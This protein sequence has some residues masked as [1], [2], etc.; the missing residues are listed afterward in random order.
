MRLGTKK[1]YL[2]I[3]A[4]Y[5]KLYREGYRTDVIVPKLMEQFFVEHQETIYR[6]IRTDVKIPEEQEC[7]TA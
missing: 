1:K 5:N 7:E 2:A 6:I 4:E 3:Q